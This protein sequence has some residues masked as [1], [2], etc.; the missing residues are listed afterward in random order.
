VNP[1][2]IVVVDD[3]DAIR[4]VV[5]AV[6]REAIPLASVT[7]HSSSLHALREIS[8]GTADLLITNCHMPDMDG[9]TLVTTIRRE[10]NAIPIIMI[11]GSDDARVLG[12]EAGIDRFVAKHAI[13]PALT[14]AIHSL[15]EAP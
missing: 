8:S 14:D 4:S 2:R 15:M 10:K 1:L 9:P 3:D 7:E 12:E 11:S 5:M 6:A 13:Y